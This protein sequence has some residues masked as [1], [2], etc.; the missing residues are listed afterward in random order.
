MNPLLHVGVDEEGV[1]L[2]V[3]E[4]VDLVLVVVRVSAVVKVEV[5]AFHVLGEVRLSWV[6]FFQ[7]QVNFHYS[8]LWIC[9]WV[10]LWWCLLLWLWL[11][12]WCNY[13][14]HCH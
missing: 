6:G 2:A 9:L 12:W 1:D 8:N 13:H 11:L 10:W 7:D 3:V 4:G 14:P 5:G